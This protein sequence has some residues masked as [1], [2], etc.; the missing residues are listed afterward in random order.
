MNIERIDKLNELGLLFNGQAF[1]YADIN[2][3][4]T[5]I[6]CMT[7]EEFDKAYEGASERLKIIEQD[8]NLNIL[9]DSINIARL[10]LEKTSTGL[11]DLAKWE[12]E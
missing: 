10:T 12:N 5:D 9:F 4:W 2:F 3:H 6:I 11:K 1:V 8:L 7:D